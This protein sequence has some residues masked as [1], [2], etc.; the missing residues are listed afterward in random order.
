MVFFEDCND[1][2]VQGLPKDTWELSQQAGRGGRNGDQAAFVI[3]LW[4]GQTG[5]HTQNYLLCC[6]EQQLQYIFI[7]GRGTTKSLSTMLLKRQ[8]S[9]QREV[10]NSLFMV[11]DP[12]SKQW[13]M[14]CSKSANLISQSEFYPTETTQQEC[15]VVCLQAETCVCSNCKCCGS[16]TAKCSCPFA[17]SDPDTVLAEFL[18]GRE[19][20]EYKKIHFPCSQDKNNLLFL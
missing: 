13:Y 10:L 3:I 17:I 18:L 16:C 12:Y 20:E 14:N 9:C 4:P 15:S 2:Y 5:Q 7:G 8:Q 11:A 1:S 19:T 6:D